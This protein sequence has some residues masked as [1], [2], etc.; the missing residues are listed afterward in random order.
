MEE[1]PGVDGEVDAEVDADAHEEVGELED[2]RT[3]R[4][5]SWVGEP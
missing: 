3:I 2:G 1:Q 5:F 4:Y